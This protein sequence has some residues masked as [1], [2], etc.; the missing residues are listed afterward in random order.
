MRKRKA[1]EEKLK[2]E[3]VRVVGMRR[4]PSTNSFH[5]PPQTEEEKTQRDF[6]RKFYSEYKQHMKPA[7][8]TGAG[9]PA[10]AAW[11]ALPAKVYLHMPAG[12]LEL[13]RRRMVQHH[14]CQNPLT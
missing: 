9:T 1:D 12:L 10:A 14:H 11:R 4:P 7:P 8:S 13:L 5:M 2:R 3:G 6:N